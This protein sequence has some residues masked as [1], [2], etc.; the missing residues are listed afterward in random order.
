MLTALD[1]DVLLHILELLDVKDILS[2]RQV[3]I[4][5]PLTT[6]LKED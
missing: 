6:S 1:V 5:Y 3:R 4:G 2:L